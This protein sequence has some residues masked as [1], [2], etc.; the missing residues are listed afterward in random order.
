MV[1]E[2]AQKLGSPTLAIALA[3]VF[4]ETKKAKIPTEYNHQNSSLLIV[5]KSYQRRL[6]P[7]RHQL[8]NG[9]RRLRS[10]II[11]RLYHLHNA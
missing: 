10:A 3:T 2:I 4:E 7:V 9:Y 8:S 11:R 5:P 6:F 1:I